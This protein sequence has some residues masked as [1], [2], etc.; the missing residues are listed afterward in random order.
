MEA[1]ALDDIPL[2][3]DFLVHLRACETHF[4]VPC[5][6]GRATVGLSIS[7]ADSCVGN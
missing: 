6:D 1:D 5:V 2:L 3:L 7:G 4:S